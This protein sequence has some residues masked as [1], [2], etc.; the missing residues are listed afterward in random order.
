MKTVMGIDMGTGSLKAVILSAAD[1]TPQAT[2]RAS[3]EYDESAYEQGVVPVQVYVAAVKKVLNEALKTFELVSVGI[4]SQMYSIC[5]MRNGELVAYQWNTVWSEDE[6]AAKAM[7]EHYETS[8]CPVKM[9]YPSYKILSEKGKGVQFK[10]F[11]FKEYVVQW[12]TGKDMVVDTVSASATGMFDIHQNV[13]NKKLTDEMGFDYA[14]MPLA[15]K[16]SFNCGLITNPEI[17]FGDQEIIVAPGIG[18]GPSASYACK[19]LS[20]IACNVG[21]S[22][23]VRALTHD[24]ASMPLKKLWRYSF[25]ENNY[26]AVGNISPFG[27]AIIDRA[28]DLG[29]LEGVSENSKT[30]L[31]FYP[32]R[33][34]DK[35]FECPEDFL[36]CMTGLKEDSTAEEIGAAIVKGIGFIICQM[37]EQVNPK[38]TEDDV[39]IIVGGGMKNPLLR[40]VLLNT[41]TI[42]TGSLSD[43]DFLVSYG[44]AM[45]AIEA[46]GLDISFE[47]ERLTIYEPTLLLAE[48]FRIWKQHQSVN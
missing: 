35:G 7:E 4:S 18:D 37:A 11:G 3:Y 38:P 24:E 10:T 28:R 23:A 48:E 6:A 36:S 22:T 12:L 21:T 20:N 42:K 29:M 30:D 2:L 5:A 8:G 25:G 19:N 15:K 43:S 14:E 16:P 27:C 32:E 34:K 45:S 9:L 31:L 26:H 44:A 41:L 17:H 46:A 39:M 33:L 13:W 1:G 47:P 40:K